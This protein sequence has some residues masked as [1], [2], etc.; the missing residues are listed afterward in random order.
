MTTRTII[1]VHIDCRGKRGGRRKGWRVWWRDR[2]GMKHTREQSAWS[3]KDAVQEAERLGIQVN[4][5]G[6][7][8][9]DF[10]ARFLADLARRCKPAT[11][12]DFKGTLRALAGAMGV[13]RLEDVTR[14]TIAGYLSLR[15]D[16]GLRPAD[17]TKRREDHRRRASSPPRRPPDDYQVQ[18]VRR[19]DDRS[20]P[21]QHASNKHVLQRMRG[22]PPQRD[23]SAF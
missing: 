11:V 6:L 13:E 17:W 16:G 9:P 22:A 3:R 20:W 7:A 14:E 1:E 19:M 23:G 2:S 15:R 4:R 12:A 10:E 18:R 8:W 21:R 5:R